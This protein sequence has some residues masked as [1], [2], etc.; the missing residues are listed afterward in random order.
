MT[1]TYD[2]YGTAVALLVDLEGVP[3][4]AALIARTSASSFLV[5]FKETYG[6]DTRDFEHRWQ[7][8]LVRRFDV[9]AEC[10]DVPN[11]TPET[12]SERPLVEVHG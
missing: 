3:A 12:T 9:L 4:L 8:Y 2:L 5:A 1:L 7:Q 10:V 6:L 11:H